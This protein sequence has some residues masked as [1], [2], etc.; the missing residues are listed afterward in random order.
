MTNN[1]QLHKA[2]EKKK[3]KKLKR[4][5][6][7]LKEN[8]LDKVAQLQYETCQ[9]SKYVPNF[10]DTVAK[11]KE[12]KGN[13]KDNKRPL[14]YQNLVEYVC[15]TRD[16]V[17]AEGCEADDLLAIYQCEAE[18]LTTVICSRDKDLKIIPG[19]HFGWACGRQPQWGPDQ[20]KELG[21]IKLAKSGKDIKGDGLL[22]FYSQVLTGDKTDHYDGLPKCGPVKAYKILQE[23]QSE[24]EMFKAVSEAYRG[25][26]GDDKWRAEMFEQC[27]LAWMIK[28]REEG[29]ELVHYVMYDERDN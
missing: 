26:Y 10:R 13:R 16:V 19:M 22:F 28:E 27:Q 8:P 23:C 15:A 3:A 21:R 1:N 9:P 20:V 18:P 5:E 11:K 12:Y 29:G 2:R 17:L 24:A 7:R 14:H 25:F 6:K 4:V